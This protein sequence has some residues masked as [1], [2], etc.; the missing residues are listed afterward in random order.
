MI[1]MAQLNRRSL[2]AGGP[3]VLASCALGPDVQ[4]A[5]REPLDAYFQV[6]LEAIASCGSLNAGGY[7]EL[8]LDRFLSS[9]L[10]SYDYAVVER[11]VPVPFF[12]AREC[13]L[14]FG[15]QELSLHAQAPVKMTLPE[16][17]RGR[18]SLQFALGPRELDP[19]DIVVVELPYARH[20]GFASSLVELVTTVHEKGAAGVVLVTTGP[21]GE[22]VPLNA[23]KGVKT[24]PLPV[25]I[26][27]S[28]HLPQL[29]A[30]EGDVA[31]LLIRGVAAQRETRN[32]IARSSS[33]EAPCILVTTP[34]SGWGPCI[35]ERGGGLVIFQYLAEALRHRFPTTPLMFVAT[36]GHEYHNAGAEIF[37]S[38]VA[39]AP[40]KVKLWVHLGA[41]LAARD[42]H[43]TPAG[44]APLPSAD[45]QRYLMGRTAD[46]EVLRASFAGQPGLEMPYP[47]EAG[48]AGE[49]AG[50]SAAG[51]RTFGAFGAHRLHHLPGDDLTTTSGRLVTPVAESFLHAIMSLVQQD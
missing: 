11:K 15:G 5:N 41:G 33:S 25:A 37:L 4:G 28:Q 23:P 40:D 48:A 46:L 18:L 1:K 8:A 29:K 14:R 22:A 9:H 6:A 24:F 2:L 10:L 35:G 51:Y 36:G 39:P 44:L 42:W 12:E 34:K 47:L 43:E 21:T 13:S 20:S 27:G 45:A 26:A 31:T 30:G 17:A 32:I 49:L 7:G 19:G 3:V 16:G 50:I 38:D